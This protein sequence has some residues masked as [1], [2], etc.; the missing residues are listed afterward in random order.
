MGFRDFWEEFFRY[1]SG[2]VGLI[3]LLGLIFMAAGAPLIAS[4]EA[5]ENWMNDAYWVENP[6]GVPPVW[7]T[8]F[9][10]KKLPEHRI[11]TEPVSGDYWEEPPPWGARVYKLVFTYDFQYDEPPKDLMFRI[12]GVVRGA[13]AP[14]IRI[15]IVRPDGLEIV[16]RCSYK[17]S[18]PFMDTMCISI[19]VSGTREAKFDPLTKGATYRFA[20]KFET[21]E[22][23]IKAMGMII[24]E[25]DI[26]FREAGPGM[27][28]GDTPL[29]RGT[30]KFIITVKM[31]NV[32][33]RFDGV[34]IIVSGKT[35]G[36]LGTD[37][38]KRDLFVG[39]VWGSRLALIVGLIGSVVSTVIGVLYGTVS[40]YLGGM[41]DEALQ[42]I[43]EIVAS[44][45]V[46]PI[47]I[48]M[49]AIFKP[50][51]WNLALMMAI[52]F[53]TG[54]VKTVRSM[55]LQIKEEP[56]VEAARA[57]G[58][59]GWRILRKYIANQVL[60]YTFALMA[61]T[62]PGVIL[63]EAGISF[64]MGGEIISEPTWGRILGDAKGYSK[65]WWW[66]LPPGLMI[67]LT[68]LSFVLI[69]YALDKILNPMLKR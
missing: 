2:V 53:W 21:E 67:C 1:K 7:V 38:R 60:P 59:S 10:G 63:T 46:L 17:F 54:P 62:V 29:L 20:K 52:F 26:V 6:K 43:Y 68:G 69:G 41:K 49:A 44:I 36:L 16:I 25:M 40:A 39:I 34:R 31:Y 19:S 9:T 15:E 11:I 32:E 65:M 57:I 61:M 50:S 51:V 22:N 58:A 42:R 30:Y 3:L 4:A 12:L 64:L 27:I 37:M 14:R 5:Y 45:P 24:D 48:L 28:F 18:E 47:L 23:M 56:Y 66:V 13:R 55:A 35:Y 8:W 33:D